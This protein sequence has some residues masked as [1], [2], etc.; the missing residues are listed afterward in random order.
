MICIVPINMH[1]IP[2]TVHHCTVSLIQQSSADFSIIKRPCTKQVY[3]LQQND[4]AFHAWCAVGIF[5][6]QAWKLYGNGYVR[7]YL[8]MLLCTSI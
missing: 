3:W 5:L 4:E 2:W 7:T 8:L 1:Y 6:L